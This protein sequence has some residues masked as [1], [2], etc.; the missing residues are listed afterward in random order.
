M[1]RPVDY[2][3]VFISSPMDV[4]EER[5]ICE[6]AINL[7]NVVYEK[8]E[9]PIRLAATRWER[10]S[11][12]SMVTTYPQAEIARQ[13]GDYEIYVG[14]LGKRFG[15]KTD[16]AG[17]GTEEEFNDACGRFSANPRSI[18]ILIY[19]KK[20]DIS[21]VPD[22]KEYERVLKFKKRVRKLNTV[23]YK[24]YSSLPLFALEFYTHLALHIEDYG[25]EWGL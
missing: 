3:K 4:K 16:N 10:D 1:R 9:R 23:L 12:P 11:Y 15:T 2:L 14:I 17:S 22:A 20:V 8:Q 13:I 5:D 7:L 6:E 21:T 19:F 18:R 25:R 24:E